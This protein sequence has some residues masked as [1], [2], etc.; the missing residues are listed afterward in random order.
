MEQSVPDHD[1]GMIAGDMREPWPTD[2]I[3]DRI[4]AARGGAQPPVDGDLLLAVLDAGTV[5]I[6]RL[7]PR[8]ASR[9]HQQMRSLGAALPAF[10]LHDQRDSGSVRLGRFDR[11]LFVQLILTP[12]AAR[13]SRRA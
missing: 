13:H 2:H 8:L 9:S 10:F 1:T 4:D 3:A 11:G 6:E 5:K 12:S 7:D